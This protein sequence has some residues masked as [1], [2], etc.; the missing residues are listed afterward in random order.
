MWGAQISGSCTAQG[1][2]AHLGGGDLKPIA[3]A[4]AVQTRVIASSPHV[5]IKSEFTAVTALLPA[6]R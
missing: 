3:A 6:L 5:S 2:A 1:K 4:R